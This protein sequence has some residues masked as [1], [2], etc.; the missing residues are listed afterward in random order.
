M[1]H[2]RI[3]MKRSVDKPSC[4][5]MTFGEEL[6]LSFSRLHRYLQRPGTRISMKQVEDWAKKPFP[7]EQI[8]IVGSAYHGYRGY[9]EGALMSANN[10]LL[11]GWGIP[12][13][14]PQEEA[15]EV[16]LL[17]KFTERV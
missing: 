2:S 12:I 6:I 7:N 11:E 9:C 16:R 4:R 13:P 17:E 15:Q 8:Y 3:R 14:S 5:L 1:A 10:A